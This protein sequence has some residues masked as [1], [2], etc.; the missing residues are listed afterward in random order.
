M[1]LFCRLI[2]IIPDN[3]LGA[4]HLAQSDGRIRGLIANHTFSMRY[5]SSHIILFSN[6]FFTREGWPDD[7]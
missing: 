4:T 5:L 6:E 2:F 3:F 1:H 7:E